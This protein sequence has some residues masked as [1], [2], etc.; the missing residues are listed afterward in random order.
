[1]R[2]VL[3]AVLAV[4]TV[5]LM[6]GCSGGGLPN[7]VPEKGVIV[8]VTKYHGVNQRTLRSMA[9]RPTRTSECAMVDPDTGKLDVFH[10]GRGKI[11][12]YA[13]EEIG[14]DLTY[15]FMVDTKEDT[16]MEMNVV[17]E[18]GVIP[19]D[20]ESFE[21]LLARFGIG[22]GKDAEITRKRGGGLEILN[23]SDEVYHI[24]IVGYYEADGGFTS[25]QV[26]YDQEYYLA[27]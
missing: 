11:F 12:G 13:A 25:F 22:M 9:G 1:M 19:F 10:F 3:A 27:E 23:A 26:L 18:K 4:M 24:A 17:C 14:G 21:E 20:G 7:K 16:V 2:R 8:D 5:C 15:S 6:A